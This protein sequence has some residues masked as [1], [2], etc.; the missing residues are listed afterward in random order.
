MLWVSVQYR[1]LCSV[2]YS[3]SGNTSCIP[4]G[5]TPFTSVISYCEPS[6]ILHVTCYVT[7]GDSGTNSQYRRWN[8]KL[9]A[10][11]LCASLN[12]ED[13]RLDQLCE[14]PYPPSAL[15][16]SIVQNI[17]Q[18]SVKITRYRLTNSWQ[19]KIIY[20][21][22]GLPPSHATFTPPEE[23]VSF[24]YFLEGGHRRKCAFLSE[25]PFI[26]LP[27]HSDVEIFGVCI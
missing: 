14:R 20:F 2:E 3:Q 25:A 18:F 26:Q 11:I 8:L 10:V 12:V 21:R 4:P 1:K 9:A 6:F 5:V 15:L 17:L 16:S 19:C 27:V 13:E 22:C 7:P 23:V 24:Y